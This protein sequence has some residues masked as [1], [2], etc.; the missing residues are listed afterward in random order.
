MKTSIIS[1]AFGAFL[2]FF[3]SVCDNAYAD[4][5]YVRKPHII[6]KGRMEVLIDEPVNAWIENNYLY[7]SCSDD[8]TDATVS[9]SNIYGDIIYLN[10]MDIYSD[11]FSVIEFDEELTG[12]HILTIIT[13]E[14]CYEIEIGQ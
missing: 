9:L 1:L 6:P 14:N 2:C 4:P 13:N 5:G 12:S 3:P 8:L 10:I 11:S 7:I